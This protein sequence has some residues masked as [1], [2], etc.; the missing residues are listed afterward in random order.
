MRLSSENKVKTAK[1]ILEFR[2]R[3]WVCAGGVS[4]GGVNLKAHLYE[5]VAPAFYKGP[6]YDDDQPGYQGLHFTCSFYMSM[7][8]NDPIE[9]VFNGNEI[10]VKVVDPTIR[11][12]YRAMR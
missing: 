11:N 8:W 5:C 6:A 10:H 4:R 12:L 2:S 9:F 1:R 3:L 7:R